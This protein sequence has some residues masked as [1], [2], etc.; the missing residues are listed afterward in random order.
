MTLIFN[1]EGVSINVFRIHQTEAQ[2]Q[3]Q[4]I[5]LDI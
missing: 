1:Y 2:T 4:V 3:N 5:G